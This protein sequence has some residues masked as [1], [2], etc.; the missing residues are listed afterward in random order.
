MMK[1]VI[2]T[3]GALIALSP[4]ALA[5]EPVQTELESSD[6]VKLEM[7]TPAEPVKE[8][9]KEIKE[10]E[11]RLREFNDDVAYAKASNSMRRGYFVLIAD[12]VEIGRMGYRHYDINPQSNFVLAQDEDGIIQF[13]FNRGDPGPNGLG[14][15]TGKGKVSNKHIE[16][17]NKGDVYLRY[18]L[19]GSNINADVTI[20]LFHNSKR[21]LAR[22]TGGTGDTDITIY[23]EILPYR[24]DEHR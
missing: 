12:Y 15:W 22:I 6:D 2:L 23:G 17:N 8:S 19:V 7:I 24:D 20:T 21:A 18:R 14:G 10:R 3:M 1:K 5:Q 16:T 4:V 9:K 13:A 11:K